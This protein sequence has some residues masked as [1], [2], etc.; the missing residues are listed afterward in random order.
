MDFGAMI[1]VIVLFCWFA[2]AMCAVANALQHRYGKDGRR[3]RSAETIWKE[4]DR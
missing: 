3:R 1:L 2:V 4:S